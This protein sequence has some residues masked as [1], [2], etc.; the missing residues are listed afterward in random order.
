MSHK[1]LDKRGRWRSVT[2]A[3]RASPE[4]R[5]SIKTL[6]KLSGLT[7]QEYLIRRCQEKEVVVVGNPRVYKARKTQMER[8]VQEL[9]RIG[10]GEPVDPE[11]LNIIRTV[12]STY[13]G[14]KTQSTSQGGTQNVQKN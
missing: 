14:M 5:D 2:I 11:L 13:E 4:E 6:A 3:F 12:I 10:A 7:L 9:Q 8:I 1:A